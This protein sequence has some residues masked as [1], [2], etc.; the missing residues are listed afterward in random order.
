MLLSFYFWGC[1]LGII[2]EVS[3][4]YIIYFV[5]VTILTPLTGCLF[6]SMTSSAKPQSAPLP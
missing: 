2:R 3:K 1:S 5:E 6:R 4:S